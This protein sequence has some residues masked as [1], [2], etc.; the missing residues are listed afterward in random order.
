MPPRFIDNKKFALGQWCDTQPDNYRKLQ[1]GKKGAYITPRKIEM[2]EQIGYALP[3]LF[4]VFRYSYFAFTNR[5]LSDLIN[6][7]SCG[8][9]E[10]MYG[11]KITNDLR[12]LRQSMDIAMQLLPRT[13]ETSPSGCG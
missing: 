8:T 12:S 3:I 7:A 13:V 11:E 1:S 2:L 9:N 4:R 6:T 5:L 10:G